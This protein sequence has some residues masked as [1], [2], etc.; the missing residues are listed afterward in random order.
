MKLWPLAAGFFAA[1][2]AT[3]LYGATVE[4]NR[5]VVERRKLRLPNWPERLDGYRIALIADL[6]LQDKS[7]VELGQRAVQEAIA[8]S[9]DAILLL[10]DYI[11]IWK[12][13]S[14]DCVADALE[15][16]DNYKGLKLAIPGNHDY[17][18]GDAAWLEPIFNEL[19]IRLLRNEALRS[20]GVA[21]VGVDSANEGYANPYIPM[22]QLVEQDN[23]DPVIVM[24]HEPDVVE[25]LPSGAALM[26]SG[27][28]HGGQFTFP[29]GWTPMHTDNGR[30][31]VKG[32]YPD[33]PTP[34]YVSR[35]IGVTGPP[36][37]LCCTPE[38][39]IL[40]LFSQ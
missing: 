17:Y 5:L 33:A 16:L 30:I 12:E 22:M 29:W 39:S 36:S 35:G 6:H 9:P 3:L 27:H 13:D 28:S 7:S 11:S 14:L 40:E 10:G 1:S 37:R 26:V 31:Y 19:G 24:W 18:F 4:A 38:V 15:E 8:A 23:T 32:Y 34:I 25:W 21:F 20:E 2:A